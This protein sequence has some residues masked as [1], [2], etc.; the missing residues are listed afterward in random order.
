MEVTICRVQ[1]NGAVD[2]SNQIWLKKFHLVG[3]DFNN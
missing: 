3:K 2:H 1:S